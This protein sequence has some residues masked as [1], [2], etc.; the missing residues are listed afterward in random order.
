[1]VNNHLSLDVE[2][3]VQSMGMQWKGR[4][5][6]LE[7]F[8]RLVVGLEGSGSR[9]FANSESVPNLC[10]WNR[11]AVIN[12]GLLNRSRPGDG[13]VAEGQPLVASVC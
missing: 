10:C 8:A 12:Q 1:M 13:R 7:L 4:I 9:C 5:A 11:F 2:I 6:R 3:C